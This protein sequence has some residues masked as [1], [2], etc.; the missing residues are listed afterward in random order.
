MVLVLCANIVHFGRSEPYAQA[1]WTVYVSKCFKGAK[2]EVRQNKD[3]LGFSMQTT[4]FAP[5]HSRQ[6]F[7]MKAYKE[8]AKFTRSRSVGVMCWT[9]SGE[10]SVR[11][12]FGP[13]THLPLGSRT[14][15][16]QARLQVPHGGAA[17]IP[18]QFGDASH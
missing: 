16:P 18:T 8:F 17:N 9:P 1:W 3:D 11:N 15:I 7:V 14:G 12:G 5:R 2:N 13:G 4:L 10:L 6:T